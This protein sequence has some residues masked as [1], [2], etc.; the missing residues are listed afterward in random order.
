MFFLFYKKMQCM[1]FSIWF[2][3]LYTKKKL[4]KS[5]IPIKQRQ[6]SGI[7]NLRH[8]LKLLKATI[9]V[10]I[11]LWRAEK[12]MENED[13]IKFVRRPTIELRK[14]IFQIKNCY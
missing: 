5:I 14:A 11:G 2:V 1:I 4:E 10:C 3:N 6:K 8:A 12:M 9:L 13:L 7:S